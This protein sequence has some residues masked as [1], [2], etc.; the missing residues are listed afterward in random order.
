VVQ[1]VARKLKG[2][3]GDYQHPAGL[4]IQ[5]T[6]DAATSISKALTEEEYGDREKYG[7]RAA[8]DVAELVA[9]WKGIP[10]STPKSVF[11]ALTKEDDAWE[12]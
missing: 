4:P 12:E 7:K 5:K 2:K 10:L 6:I 3:W 9:L 8:E 11:K 1:G